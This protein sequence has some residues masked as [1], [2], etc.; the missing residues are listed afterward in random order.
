MR[1]F[2]QDLDGLR[3]ALL[4]MGALAEEMIHHA[5]KVLVERDESFAAKVQ[6]SERRVNELHIDIDDRCLKLIALHQPAG[7]A[8][9]RTRQHRDRATGQGARD[10]GL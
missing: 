6:E 3:S 10:T 4:Q 1:H 5:V 7:R 8:D 9:H 2:D